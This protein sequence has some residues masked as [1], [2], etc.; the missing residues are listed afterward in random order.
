[1]ESSLHCAPQ[2]ARLHEHQGKALLA[3]AGIKIPRG[4]VASS[5]QAAE[6]VAEQLG[7]ETVVKIQAWMTGRKGIGGVAFATTPAQAA[8]AADRMI[9]MRV[10]VGSD[11]RDLHSREIARCQQR[12]GESTGDSCGWKRGCR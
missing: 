8:V 10:G 6:K 5:A 11:L 9:G 7:C 1:M 4:A 3:A 2:M 12:R